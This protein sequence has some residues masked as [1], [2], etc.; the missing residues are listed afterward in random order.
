MEQP[1][2]TETR[3]RHTVSPVYALSHCAS[4]RL[5]DSLRVDPAH[6]LPN[7]RRDPRCRCG[8]LI[9]YLREHGAW[10][11]GIPA[12]AGAALAAAEAQ[13]VRL[14][15]EATTAV[16]V[17][18]LAAQLLA[19]TVWG[20]NIGLPGVDLRLYGPGSIMLRSGTRW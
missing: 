1:V 18:G 20:L 17:A 16:L 15:G 11:K 6:R 4:L 19:S 14:P 12:M 10:P 5:L 7:P 13:T 9:T 8:G 3:W 2:G